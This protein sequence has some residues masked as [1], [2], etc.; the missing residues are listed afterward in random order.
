[1]YG[2]P[3]SI[4]TSVLTAACTVVEV[5]KPLSSVGAEIATGDRLIVLTVTVAEAAEVDGLKLKVG[6]SPGGGP[7][8]GIGTDT[9]AIVAEMSLLIE[10][11]VARAG[12]ELEA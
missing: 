3:V 9:D 8:Y 2:T 10:A 7:V 4:G 12:T 11:A 6:K 5:V 1:M